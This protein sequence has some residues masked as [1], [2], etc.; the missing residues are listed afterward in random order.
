MIRHWLRDHPLLG[1]VALAFT[2]S[3]GGILTILAARGFDLSPMLPLEA[4]LILAAMLLG[5]SVSGLILTV[6][7]DGRAGMRQLGARLLRRQFGAHWY[8]V[9]LLTMP[10][11]LLTL[12]WLL[13]A[14]I[15]PAYSPRFQWPLFAVGLIAGSF[16][17][18]GWTGFATPRLVAG[19][20]LAVA[21]CSLGLTWA[22]WHLLVD[23]RHNI[24]T[25]GVAWPLKFAIVYLATLTPYRMLMTWVYSHTQSLFL[26]ILMH[27]SFTGWLLILFPMTSFTLSLFWQSVLAL[28]LW[29][30][31]VMAL[32]SDPVRVGPSALVPVDR[33][34]GPQIRR[35]P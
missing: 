6:L 2:I 15:D 29:V 23:F 27:A 14:A 25:M 7:M 24:G 10:A 34:I 35:R 32:Q 16:E 9:A 4:G 13:S 22:L 20:G 11:I 1:Y 33:T 28:S 12:L 8:A 3:W 21:G 19:Y 31:A 5:P 18:I 26:A 17:E 30:V